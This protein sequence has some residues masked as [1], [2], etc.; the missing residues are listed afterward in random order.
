MKL[1]IEH[2][3]RAWF[4]SRMNITSL[5]STNTTLLIRLYKIFVKPYMHYACTVLTA[6]KKHKQTDLK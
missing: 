6:L 2:I 4:L 5:N 1:H 3:E